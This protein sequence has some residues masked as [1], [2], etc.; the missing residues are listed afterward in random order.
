MADLDK[1]PDD[2]AEDKRFERYVEIAKAI[3]HPSL[4]LEILS[5][6][7]EH[8]GE[9]DPLTGKSILSECIDLVKGVKDPQ[10]RTQAWASIAAS[11]HR[12]GDDK[13]AH[14]ALDHA[15]DDAA[16]LYKLDLDP[17]E[18]NPGP[19]DQWPSTNAYRRVVIAGAKVFGVDADV[20]LGRI[21]DPDIALFARIEMA[22]A[23]LDRP[24]NMWMT[25]S[26]KTIK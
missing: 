10:L 15:F 12:L 16:I 5:S 4:R 26:G 20:L 25:W 11:A 3:R 14:E 19:R 7:I 18:P 21:S 9:A 13:L 24:H 2:L 17:D 23:L 6:T 8:A 1:V 22:Q